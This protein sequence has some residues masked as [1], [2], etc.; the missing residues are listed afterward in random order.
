[1]LSAV[2]KESTKITP[3]VILD[4]QNQRFSIKG[5]SFPENTL[6]FYQPILQWIQQYVENPNENTVFEFDMEYF[7]SSSARIV[8][9]IL[10]MLEKIQDKNKK[11]VCRWHINKTD[12]IGKERIEEMRKMFLIPIEINEK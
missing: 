7:N 3:E 12:Y 11:V 1:M 5:R 10:L 4:Q 6:E 2:K 8:Y 9:K